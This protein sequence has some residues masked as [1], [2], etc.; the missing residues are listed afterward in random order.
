MRDA[1]RRSGLWSSAGVVA[2]GCAFWAGQ[3]LEARAQSLPNS[4]PTASAGESSASLL[5][6]YVG[7]EVDPEA[8]LFVTAD[9]LNYDSRGEAASAEG[10]VEAVYGARVLRADRLTYDSQADRIQAAGNVILLNDDGSTLFAESADLSADLTDG[11]I[12]QPTARI[13]GGGLLMGVEGRREG[14][15]LALSKA[16]YSPCAIC[17]TRRQ[18]LWSLRARRATLDEASHDVI[19][20]D[21]SFQIFGQTV[22]TLPYFRHPDPTV[23]RR[24][25]FLAPRLGWSKEIG[26]TAKTPFFWE[27]APDKDLTFTPYLATNDGLILEA[28]YR[29]LTETGGY[30][31]GGSLGHVAAN[32]NGEHWRGH[33]DADGRFGLTDTLAWGFDVN[34]ASDDTYLRRYDFTDADRLTSRLYMDR[35]TETAYAELNGFYFQSFRPEEDAATIPLVLPELRA[36]RTLVADPEW[37]FVDV[38]SSLLG[39][40]RR[41]GRD[42]ARASAGVNWERPFTL[43]SG[44]RVTPFA[45]AR[46]VGYAQRDQPVDE[47]DLVGRVD[48]AVGVDARWPFVAHRDSGIHVI[49]PIVQVVAA[50]AVKSLRTPNE[51]SIDIEFDET[52]L[53]SAVSRFPGVDRWE[54]GTRLNAGVRYDFTAPTGEEFEAAYGRVFRFEDDPAFSSASGLRDRSSDHVAMAR[55]ALPEYGLEA[56]GRVRL[57]EHDLTMRRGE[58]YASADFNP[59]SL[60]VSYV[61]LDADPEAGSP[62]RRSE[63]GLGV[64]WRVNPYWTVYASGVRDLE[65]KDLIR[66]GGGLR[67]EDECLLFDASVSRRYT[68]DRDAED[69]LSFGLRAQ[70]KFPGG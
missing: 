52:T 44:L 17:E 29:S 40:T 10:E 66:T 45:T 6:R 56:L 62:V 46:A 64:E 65:N 1:S 14:E 7:A 25:G 18:P 2:L 38:E 3:P 9:S 19:Y 21:P 48:A 39:L 30:R 4:L 63:L 26:V 59:V 67:Y 22:L 36:R 49:E 60:E 57:D 35:Q 24:T 41:E 50:P 34:L 43:D 23:S 12:A 20:E 55:V 42:L 5:Q 51:D 61:T 11:Q 54:G 31:L 70:L 53:F 68:T 37:G 69:D 28:E 27:L 33:L 58:L 47:S 15:A 32:D 13:M 8:R 16:V